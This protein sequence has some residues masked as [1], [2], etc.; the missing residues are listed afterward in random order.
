MAEFKIKLT[1]LF[2]VD[3][4]KILLKTTKIFTH[5]TLSPSSVSADSE[6]SL[7]SLK[8]KCGILWISRTLNPDRH[9]AVLENLQRL[10]QCLKHSSANLICVD[11]NLGETEIKFWADS[12]K[13]AKKKIFIR[14][15]HRA[16]PTKINS[17]FSWII[18][19]IADRIIAVLLLFLFSPG[20]V[21]LLALL[22]IK[23]QNSIFSRNWKIGRRGRLFQVFE[24]RS[25]LEEI[26]IKGYSEIENQI[27]YRQ[28]FHDKISILDRW[29]QK[30]SFD[31]LPQLV[32][33]I[34][35][36]MSIVGP[37][38]LTLY[39]LFHTNSKYRYYL[40]M[41]PGIIGPYQVETNS[42]L[43]DIDQGFYLEY[44][45]SKDWN[46]MKDIKILWRFLSNL[47]TR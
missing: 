13:Q 22:Y 20:F 30:L 40:N 34:C 12:C 10:K 6:K 9:L 8:W 36:E 41:P 14:L 25:V 7:C 29:V 42:T 15:V 23:S 18:K 26:Q 27:L 2:F 19:S 28:N 1:R 37:R 31:K 33:V 47:S 17:T 16:N 45:Y 35:G 39:D 5:Q 11:S 24:I 4:L 43:L 3:K 32:N 38:A 21:I 44:E 46:L